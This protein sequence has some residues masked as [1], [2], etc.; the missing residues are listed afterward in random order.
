MKKIFSL[1]LIL[2]TAFINLNAESLLHANSLCK[3]NGMYYLIEDGRKCP[4]ND[5]VIT[6]KLKEGTCEVDKGVVSLRKNKLGYVDVAVPDSVS[7]EDF[8][9]QLEKSGIYE[10]IKYATYGETCV[11]SND[12][13]IGQQWYLDSI[14][15][16]DAWNYTM[17]SPNIKIAV[18]DQIPFFSHEDMYDASASYNNI[19]WS[20][21]IDFTGRASSSYHG[22]AV[23]GIISA[24]S[25]NAIGV[26]GICGGNNNEGACIIPYNIS[27]VG[28]G[29]DMSCVDDAI[30]DA[31]DKGVKVI[32]MSFRSLSSNYPE[33]NDAITYAKN[34]DV[35]LVASSGN[36]GYYSYV[37][38][39][40]SNQDVISVG[41]VGQSLQRS[42]FSNAGSA[43][44]LVA[45]GE[46]IYTLTNN[47]YVSRGGTSFSAPQVAAVIGLMLSANPQLSADEI[48][49]LIES[50]AHRI[51]IYNYQTFPEHP[52][53][54]WTNSVGY[55]VLDAYAAVQGAVAARDLQIS[56]PIIPGSPSTYFIP[57]L[58]PGRYVEWSLDGHDS[59]PSYCTANYPVANHL[60][61]NNNAKEHIKGTLVAKVFNS[62]GILINTLNNFINTADGFVGSYTQTLPG[63]VLYGSI[64]DESFIQ[65]KQG[66]NVVLTSS[67]FYGASVSYTSVSSQPMISTSGNTI[68]IRFLASTSFSKCLLHCVKG[69]KVIEFRLVAEPAII[70]NPDFP[71]LANVSNN[72]NSTIN[73]ELIEQQGN[74]ELRTED[75][76]YVW[77]L[78]VYSA[79]TGELVHEQQVSGSSVS[80]ESDK[81]KPDIYMIKIK[82]GTKELTQKISLLGYPR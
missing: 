42:V 32:N 5:K 80:I 77:N 55:G 4:V 66:H 30:I 61:I 22:M 7:I 26:A 75:T 25:N 14:K 6:V 76:L 43:L 28:E 27:T 18:I 31:T 56:G 73:V 44:D 70:L 51:S 34:H 24:K 1:L 29:V 12:E 67:D 82:F 35:L 37:G 59:L 2:I 33:I 63:D 36:D 64:Y 81:W 11:T 3:E 15:V 20:L 46:Q 52:N 13:Y 9:C 49:Y 74:C 53:G 16:F 23:A 54:A 45:P 19:N 69:D 17:G 68:T 65:V 50:T 41:S 79:S 58:L 40:A 48:R 38:Y 71:I 60:Q 21:G 57:N 8:A 47:T 72:G 62:N 78:Y 39:P 10:I